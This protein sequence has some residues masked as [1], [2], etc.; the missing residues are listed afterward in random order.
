MPRFTPPED[1]LSEGVRPGTLSEQAIFNDH[2]DRKILDKSLVS[3]TELAAARD[4]LG[5]FT[6]TGAHAMSDTF[7]ALLKA[8]PRIVEDGQLR[9]SHLVNALVM[10]EALQLPELQRLRHLTV[11]DDVQA[12]LSAAD[13]EPDIESLFDKLE[14]EQQQASDLQDLLEQLAG[15]VAD[16]A[17]AEA[18]FAAA[19]GAAGQGR[20]GDGDDEGEGQELSPEQQ[21][22]LNARAEAVAK[23]HEAVEKLRAEA[24]AAAR[25]LGEAMEEATA[26][27]SVTMAE[28]LGK[29]ADAAM[30][31]RQ[32]A[33][34]WG[35]DPGELQ[36]MSADERLALAKTLKGDRF[37]RIADRWGPMHSLMLSE[38]ARRTNNVPEEIYDTELGNNLGRLLPSELSSLHHPLLRKNF[39]RKF[40][41][42]G[43]MQYALRGTEKLSRGGIIFCEDGSGSMRGE[44]EIWAKAVMLCLLDLAKRQK[45]EMHVVHFGG[46]GM[47][48][49]LEFTKPSDF[50][51]DHIVEAAELFFGGGTDF[52]TPMEVSLDIL[53]RQHASSGAVRADVVFLTDDECYV[54]DTFMQEYLDEMHRMQAT[55]WGISAAGRVTRGGALDQMCEG[56]TCVVRDFLSGEDVR[57]VFGGV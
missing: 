1:W 46:R 56:K 57:K 18:D 8:V 11:N 26:T 17:N 13:L 52:E 44:R 47:Y 51:F 41:G 50:T 25:E 27:V 55:T 49:H 6:P 16:L 20:G 36:R 24:E 31:T 30:D 19:A 48:R 2:W 9:P 21:A 54:R 15:A 29:A 4:Q 10:E 12:A 33:L 37:R 35:I 38:Q 23:A 39:L 7:W 28:A 32:S 45:R 34:A 22:E 40:V 3:I 42:R 5:D 53:R 14:Q 43:L